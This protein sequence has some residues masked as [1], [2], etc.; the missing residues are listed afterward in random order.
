MPSVFDVLGQDHQEVKRMLAELEKGP[1]A[2]TGANDNHLLLRKKMAEEL[3]I[4]ES[5]H[6]A[7]EEM[8]LWPAVRD[9]LPN[10]DELADTATGQEQEGKKVLDQLDKLNADQAEFEELVFTFINAGREHIAFE[11]TKVW[12]PLRA[13]LTEDEAARLGEQIAEAKKT[14]PTRP[15]PRTPPSPGVLKGAGPVVGAADRLRDAATDRGQD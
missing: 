13:T 15:H 5:R 2:A 8:Y 4:E 6:E 9:R 11:E 1:T 7:A 3:I 10:G 12:P 14:A